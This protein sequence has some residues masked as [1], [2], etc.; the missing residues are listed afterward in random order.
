MGRFWRD[1]GI[2]ALAAVVGYLVVCVACWV[3]PA[4]ATLAV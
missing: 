3:F 4:L 1:L 2:G